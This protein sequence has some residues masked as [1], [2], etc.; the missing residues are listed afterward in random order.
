MIKIRKMFEKVENV[1]LKKNYLE[2]RT[3]Q[4]L[5]KDSAKWGDTQDE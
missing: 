4:K 2:K 5:L 3:L 1:E